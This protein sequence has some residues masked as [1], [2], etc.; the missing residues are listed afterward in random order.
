MGVVLGKAGLATSGIMLWIGV[1]ISFS[2]YSEMYENVTFT[3]ESRYKL[4]MICF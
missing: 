1:Q 3:L 4:C 2:L